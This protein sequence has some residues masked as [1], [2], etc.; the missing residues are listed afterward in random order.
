MFV[1]PEDDIADINE[2]ND[3]VQMECKTNNQQA[4]TMNIGEKYQIVRIK[5]DEIGVYEG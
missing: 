1:P 2:D 3:V 4:L 5:A